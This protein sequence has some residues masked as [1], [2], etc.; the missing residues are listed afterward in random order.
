MNDIV[1]CCHDGAA[2][3]GTRSRSSRSDMSY[4]FTPLLVPFALSTGCLFAPWYFARRVSDGRTLA[5]L[6]L[7]SIPIV[8]WSIAVMFRLGG[9]TIGVERTWHNV[10]FIGP[11][12]GSVGFLLFTRL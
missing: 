5:A 9:T 1:E 10:R 3:S 7:W 4:E 12:F 6:M 11:A 2:E 8:V